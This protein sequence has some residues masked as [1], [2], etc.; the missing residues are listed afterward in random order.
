[1]PVPIIIEMFLEWL[2]E[3]SE[4]GAKEDQLTGWILALSM[5]IVTFSKP[6]I[7]HKGIGI[8]HRTAVQVNLL[9]RGL[10]ID[11]AFN[12][13]PGSRASVDQ[14]LQITMINS[15]SRN[16]MWS[17]MIR[18]NI[19]FGVFLALVFTFMLYL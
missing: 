2:E 14:G 8:L 6:Y 11:K 12:I 18:H 7:F 19:Y 3:Q 9:V 17:I 1:M 10:I 16:L 5:M 13:P 15:D 4:P